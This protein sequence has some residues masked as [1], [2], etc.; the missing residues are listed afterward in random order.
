ME[1][2]IYIF[3]LNGQE[4]LPWSDDT[5]CVMSVKVQIYVLQDILWHQGSNVQPI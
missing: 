5:A 4:I 3:L 2:Y 1:E